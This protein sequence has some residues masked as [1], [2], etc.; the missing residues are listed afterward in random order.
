MSSSERYFALGSADSEPDRDNGSHFT[1]TFASFVTGDVQDP[2]HRVIPGYAGYIPDARDN[3]T[4][5]M[6]TG[7]A[8]NRV[9]SLF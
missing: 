5:E 2:S 8:A 3:L 6:V 7:S 9:D 1:L 4:P